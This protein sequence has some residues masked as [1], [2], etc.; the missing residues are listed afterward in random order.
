M[1]KS[2]LTSLPITQLKKNTIHLE[3]NTDLNILKTLA[4]K[5]EAAT[6]VSISN[7]YQLHIFHIDEIL[8]FENNKESIGPF[9]TAVLIEGNEDP[10]RYISRLLVT[11]RGCKNIVVIEVDNKDKLKKIK[12]STLKFVLSSEMITID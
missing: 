2:V 10:I 5:Y 11:A 3:E 9:F 1:F 8:S 7:E 4:A 12:D 6:G